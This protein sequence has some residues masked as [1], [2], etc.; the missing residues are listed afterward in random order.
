MRV[1]D[2]TKMINDVQR[3]KIPQEDRQIVCTAVID[4]HKKMNAVCATKKDFEMEYVQ[5]ENP[6]NEIL[7]KY[8]DRITKEDLIVLASIQNISVSDEETKNDIIAKIKGE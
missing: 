1:P 5:L 4:W 7:F 8:L 3:S 6:T 2:I